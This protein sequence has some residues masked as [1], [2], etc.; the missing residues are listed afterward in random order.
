MA[1]ILNIDLVGFNRLDQAEAK[2][3]RWLDDVKRSVAQ[4]GISHLHDLMDAAFRNPTPYYETQV[5]IQSA[6]DAEVIHDRGVVYGPWLEGVGSRNAT[7]RFK[8]YFHW[9]R[10]FQHLEE[11]EGPAIL[12]RKFPELVAVL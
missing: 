7:T 6:G 2:I 11:V 1:P 10:T 3:D 9:R 4:Q 5:T 12:N 8:G